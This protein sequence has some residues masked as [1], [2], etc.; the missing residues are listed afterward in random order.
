MPGALSITKL[1]VRKTANGGPKLLRDI[2]AMECANNV[3]LIG[4]A[5]AYEHSPEHNLTTLPL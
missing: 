3:A 4:L 2:D 1:P 5:D